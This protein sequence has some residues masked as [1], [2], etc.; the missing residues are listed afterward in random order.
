MTASLDSRFMRRSLMRQAHAPMAT[1]SALYEVVH[2]PLCGGYGMRATRDMP[3]GSFVF[4][5]QPLACLASATLQDLFMTDSVMQSILQEIVA[6]NDEPPPFSDRAWWPEPTPAPIKAIQRFAEIEFA[7][8][9]KSAQ[10]K[11]MALADSF[12][13]PGEKSPG[14]VMRSNAFTDAN[15]GDNF[16]YAHLSRANHSC[17]PNMQRSFESAGLAVVSLL[18]DVC[19]GDAL[20]ISY[21]SDD[22]LELPTGER[23]ALLQEKF[24][25]TCECERCGPCSLDVVV[26]IPLQRVDASLGERHV[27]P[28]ART[29]E[30]PAHSRHDAVSVLS[31]AQHAL[32]RH[33]EACTAQMLSEPDRDTNGLLD[34][35]RA[36]SAALAATDRARRALNKR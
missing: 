11:W 3:A 13:K 34:A 25:F 12:S 16:L 8:M 19:K 6:Q 33:L 26:D 9:P 1:A 27:P 15:T 35:V 20:L 28:H 21:L 29:S 32:S 18:R 24:G 22:D 36:C 5:E 23:R 4:R 10:E 30:E 2:T 31:D 14:N 17:A 7:K